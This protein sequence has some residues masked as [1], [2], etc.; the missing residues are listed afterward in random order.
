M[1]KKKDQYISRLF[2][3]MQK[4]LRLDSKIQSIDKFRKEEE[5]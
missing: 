5:S 4:H 2:N 1:L 3:Q